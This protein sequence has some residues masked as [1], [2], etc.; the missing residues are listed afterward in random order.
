MPAPMKWLPF[1][2]LAFATGVTAQAPFA[3]PA[4]S[5]TTAYRN[6]RIIDGTGAA[7]RDHATIVVTGERIAAVVDDAGY[8]PPAGAAVVDLAGRTIIPGL[9]DSH[10]HMA[11]P[12]NAVQA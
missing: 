6:V 9:V 3:P 11:T 8:T 4:P 5:S 7:P 1:L 10:V 2:T 12:P